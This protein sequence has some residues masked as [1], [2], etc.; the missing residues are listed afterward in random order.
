MGNS[1]EVHLSK[2]SAAQRQLDAAIR[3][4][5]AR[6]DDL[7]VYTVAAAAHR[8]L[9]DIMDKRDRSSAAESLRDGV[10]GLANAVARDVLPDHVRKE[11][12]GSEIWTV[13]LDLAKKIKAGGDDKKLTVVASRDLDRHFWGFVAKPANFLKHADLDADAFLS[14]KELPLDSLL[15]SA[16]MTYLH[17]IGKPTPEM[18]VLCAFQCVEMEDRSPLPSYLNP[19]ADLLE[20]LPSDARSDECSRLISARKSE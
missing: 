4:R 10:R 18:E 15:M 12:E 11:F 2:L 14:M 3:M 19:I 8:I 16:C 6:E 17:L 13:V 7:A 20:T 1:A 5:F 9:R